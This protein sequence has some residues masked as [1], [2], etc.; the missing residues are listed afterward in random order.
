MSDWAP[1]QPAESSL[2]FVNHWPWLEAG[3]YTTEKDLHTKSLIRPV[4]TETKCAISAKPR[5]G[6]LWK[7][8]GPKECASF[9]FQ[10]STTN[11]LRLAT[12]AQSDDF[13]G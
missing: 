2:K 12:V 6:F 10:R 7:G 1:L 5:V 11:P 9:C 8:G 4:S 13:P 3:V